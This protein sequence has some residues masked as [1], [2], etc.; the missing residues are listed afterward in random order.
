MTKISEKNFSSGRDLFSLAGVYGTE[1]NKQ[2]RKVTENLGVTRWELCT[3]K[4]T[5]ETRYTCTNG[6][7]DQKR[8]P[9]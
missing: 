8:E 4:I 1:L 7:R 9:N 3:K 5:R 2:V 6:E